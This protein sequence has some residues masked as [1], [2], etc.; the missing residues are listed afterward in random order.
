MKLSIFNKT[1][2]LEHQYLEA[3]KVAL[4][5]AQKQCEYERSLFNDDDK[6]LAP[7]INKIN[8]LNDLIR[9]LE[10]QD[11]CMQNPG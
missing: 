2:K 11:V 9:Y 7:T 1:Y 5:D 10:L 8:R 4:L 6:Q 3:L